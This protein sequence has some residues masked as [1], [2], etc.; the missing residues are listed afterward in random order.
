LECLAGKDLASQNPK[1]KIQ[2]GMAMGWMISFWAGLTYPFRALAVLQRNPN[3]WGYV[4]VP[5]LINLVLGVTIYAGLLFLGLGLIDA[6]FNSLPHWLAEAS[7]EV[8]ADVQ[9]IA[10]PSPSDWHISWPGW[11][12]EWHIAWPEWHIAWPDWLP[13]LPQWNLPQWNLPQLNLRWP[14]WLPDV[15]GWRLTIPNWVKELPRWG[16]EGVVWLIRLVLTL[17][18]FLITGFI[19]LQFG[20]I[21]GAPWYGK[22]SEELEKLRTGQVRVVDVGLV[23][24]IWRA[25]LYEL[26]KLF[27]AVLIGIPLLLLGLFPVFGK[28]AATIGSITLA[29]TLVCMDFLDPPLERRRLSFRQ[30][31]GIISRNLPATATFGILCFGLVSIPLLNLLAIP[32]CITAGTLFF[33]DRVLPKLGESPALNSKSDADKL[34]TNS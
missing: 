18:L 34:L 3:L 20:V 14:D 9:A 22:L 16:V 23:G 21:L 25:I 13:A 2:N 1:S 31:F 8:Q 26:K 29:T 19:L 4:L 24:D 27:V 10:I 32:V 15:S 5:I 28:L 33:C 30:K 11:W 12:P 6:F 7:H 17:L